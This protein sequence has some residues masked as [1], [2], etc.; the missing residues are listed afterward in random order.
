MVIVYYVMFRC[1][2]KRE[3]ERERERE[4]VAFD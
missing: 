2:R 3:R 4:R 1:F